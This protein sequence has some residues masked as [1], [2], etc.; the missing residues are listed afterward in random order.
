MTVAFTSNNL[1]NGNV[2]SKLYNIG[3]TFPTSYPRPVTNKTPP[4]GEKPFL[5]H[6][7][8]GIQQHDESSAR[9]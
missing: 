8:M 6:G 5:Q 1:T 4:S 2:I 7:T 9:H 3:R